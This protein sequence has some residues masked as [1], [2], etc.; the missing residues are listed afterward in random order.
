MS[1]CPPPPGAKDGTVT[2]SDRTISRQRALFPLPGAKP[3]WWIV[4]EVGRRMGWK[5]AFAYDRPAEI[6]REHCRLSAYENDGARLFALPG[7]S[8]AG[9]ADYEAMTPFRWGGTPLP[10]AASRPPMP[11][12]GW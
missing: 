4:K 8:S 6:W 5:T 10:M 1:A 12:R 7:R 9:N 11:A 2:N 3:D